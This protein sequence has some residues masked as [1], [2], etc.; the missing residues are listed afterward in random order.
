MYVTSPL[1]SETTITNASVFSDIP[2]PALC[3]KPYLF[4]IEFESETGSIIL[5]AVIVMDH[6]YEKLIQLFGVLSQF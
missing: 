4:G 1:C 2:I 3:L 6:F 5:V